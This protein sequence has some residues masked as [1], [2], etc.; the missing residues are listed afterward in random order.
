[1][2]I[3]EREREAKRRAKRKGPWP[4]AEVYAVIRADT[5]LYVA[6]MHNRHANRVWWLANSSWRPGKFKLSDGHAVLSNAWLILPVPRDTNRPL[7]P[8]PSH[9]TVSAACQRLHA[10]GDM[11]LKKA[12]TK[13]KGPGGAKRL[14]AEYGMPSRHGGEAPRL[15]WPVGISRPEGKIYLPVQR[16]RWDAAELSTSAHHLLC[17]LIASHSRERHG[18]VRNS[19]PF[20][21][22]IEPTAELLKLSPATVLAARN[23]LVAKRRLRLIQIGAGKRAATFSLA[24]VYTKHQRSDNGDAL[25]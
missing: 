7:A 13:P 10:S 23:E 5:A 16:I 21:V 9:H 3:L 4:V 14:A 25:P 20:P 8:L 12:G 17:L 2:S 15:T 19:E 6:L 18:T 1:M 24:S 22:P 11:P